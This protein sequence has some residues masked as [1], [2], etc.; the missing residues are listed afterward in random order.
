MIGELMIADEGVL[1]YRQGPP[2][3]VSLVQN[4]TLAPILLNTDHPFI[5]TISSMMPSPDWFSGF[6]DVSMRDPQ[7]GTWYDKVVIDTYPW[8]AGTD[9]GATYLAQ[10]S[11]TDPSY[12]ITQL[13]VG[14]VPNSEVFLNSDGTDVLPVARWT[15]NRVE[16]PPR[17][18][19]GVPSRTSVV[20]VL[21]LLGS[22][23][24][25]FI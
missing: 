17:P 23:T 6:Y 10:A 13:T 2:M 19:S 15:C 1:D 25:L 9:S 21:L 20:T 4:A 11:P 18:T 3:N 5:S 16:A 12:L 24:M 8:D 7:S 22:T 14:T